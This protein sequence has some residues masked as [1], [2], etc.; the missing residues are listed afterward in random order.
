[1]T[2]SGFQHR[3]DKL[4]RSAGRTGIAIGI[5][6]LVAC[7][8]LFWAYINRS[9]RKA[10]QAASPAATQALA[11]T[12]P[13]LPYR[14]DYG[15]MVQ[16]KLCSASRSRS[17]PWTKNWSIKAAGGTQAPTLPAYESVAAPLPVYHAVS[18]FYV[19]A[20]ALMLE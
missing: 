20:Q 4:Y 1:M 12:I 9:T 7:I 14:P 13:E 2:V 10:A 3:A 18:V 19:N 16:C 17:V 8:F 11:R 15:V 5:S 6:A